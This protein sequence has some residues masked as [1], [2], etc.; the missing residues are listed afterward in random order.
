MECRC[1]VMFFDVLL[2]NFFSTKK[3]MNIENIQLLIFNIVTYNVSYDV[4]RLY[5]N[6]KPFSRSRIYFLSMLIP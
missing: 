3:F 5:K 2:K 4:K 6:K 1:S